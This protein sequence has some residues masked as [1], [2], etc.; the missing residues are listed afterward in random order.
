MPI[1]KEGDSVYVEY[2]I[3]H[4]IK[5]LITDDFLLELRNQ[6][7]RIHDYYSLELFAD[8]GIPMNTSTSGWYAAFGKA[9]LLTNKLE[10]L[11]YW[12]NLEYYDSDIFDGEL[13]EMLVEK[14]LILGYSNDVL[15][16]RLKISPECIERCY[17]CGQLC[18]LYIKHK[19]DDDYI[20]CN[21]CS[22]EKNDDD[23]V[24]EYIKN[25]FS[26]KEEKIKIINEELNIP[27]DDLVECTHCKKIFIKSM[28]NG[29]KCLCCSDTEKFLNRSSTAS[30]YYLSVLQELKNI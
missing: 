9:C 28:M 14:K 3:P 20:I 25:I 22:D 7:F 6:L 4:N 18:S 23:K 2:A 12:K 19:E 15:A 11:K 10:L 21:S 26:K 13:A 17:E 8:E 16:R 29:D 30:T 5:T 27:I 1:V 24:K